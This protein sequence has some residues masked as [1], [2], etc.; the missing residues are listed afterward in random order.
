MYMPS[1]FLVMSLYL[2]LPYVRT[3]KNSL[4]K[5]GLK[6]SLDPLVPTEAH[7]YELS[8]IFENSSI[9]PCPKGL[10]CLSKDFKL[11]VKE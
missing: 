10:R 7:D 8:D 3:Y 6:S 4:K 5:G 1:M 11:K 2:F 9:F